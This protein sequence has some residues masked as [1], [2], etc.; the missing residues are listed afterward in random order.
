MLHEPLHFRFAR[1]V[2]IQWHSENLAPREPTSNDGLSWHLRHAIR[3]NCYR[4]PG[5]VARE[6][7]RRQIFAY[8]SDPD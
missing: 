8:I 3:C 1:S 7:E 6:L 5:E 4:L 2:N